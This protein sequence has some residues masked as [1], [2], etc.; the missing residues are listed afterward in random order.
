MCGK[1]ENGNVCAV[2]GDI[3]KL[4]IIHLIYLLTTGEFFSCVAELRA[5]LTFSWMQ[6]SCYIANWKKVLTYQLRHCA[7]CNWY[8]VFYFRGPV[9]DIAVH[10]TGR[11][12]VSVSRDK[13]MKTWNL[14]TGKRAYTTNT[15]IGKAAQTVAKNKT[16]F[17]DWLLYPI[18]EKGMGAW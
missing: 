5:P 14:M 8:T 4:D 17:I 1:L 2:F 15:K 16:R 3:S 11:L 18:N 7:L 13:T 10:P 9:H 12:A 6:D